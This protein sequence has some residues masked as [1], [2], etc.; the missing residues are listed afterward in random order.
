MHD[1]VVN[2]R[3]QKALWTLG[4]E[5]VQLCFT[6]PPY[7]DMITYRE[8]DGTIISQG[9]Q[10]S[11]YIEEF[12][13]GLFICLEQCMKKDGMVAVVV[14]D[15]KRDGAKSTANYEGL[16]EVCNRGWKLIDEVAWIK[17]TGQPREPVG[18]LD[19]WEHIWLLSKSG[20]PKFYP[21]RI[22]GR[23]SEASVQRYAWGGGLVRKIANSAQRNLSKGR[24]NLFA[25]KDGEREQNRIVNIDIA[26]GK[27]MPNVLI[28]SPDVGRSRKHPARFPLNLPKWGI[29][30]CTDPGDLV[31]DPMCGS[32]TTL[33]AAKSA[34]RT[35]W[36]CDIGKAYVEM[37]LKE[38]AETE[39][40]Q[41]SLFDEEFPVEVPAVEEAPGYEQLMMNLDERR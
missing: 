15:K 33:V 10:R 39:F 31:I 41:T 7:E 16:I 21:S 34:G 35:Y 4:V 19:W 13:I 23:Y 20:R 26:K 30:L 37:A 2:G 29:T 18:F 9:A 11:N 36:G 17:T 22:R 40:L 27:L 1:T 25:T 3:F 24:K 14:N 12:W 8:A 5:S 38:L 6:S 32:G 28:V